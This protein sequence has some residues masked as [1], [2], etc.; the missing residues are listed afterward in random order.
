MSYYVYILCSR[1]NGTLYVGITND[2]ARR[3]YEHKN[4]NFRGFTAKYDVNQLVYA[5]VYEDVNEAI[6]R[7]KRLKKWN[8]KWKINLIEKANPIWEDISNRLI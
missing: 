6:C 8:R 7:E 1:R 4:K 2:L 3:L 5:E